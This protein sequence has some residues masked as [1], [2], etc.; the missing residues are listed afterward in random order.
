[1]Y[2]AIHLWGLTP[3]LRE[4]ISSIYRDKG[5]EPGDFAAPDLAK[6]A[7]YWVDRPLTK[8]D[9]PLREQIKES[10][11]VIL[12]SSEEEDIYPFFDLYFSGIGLTEEEFLR[13]F[14]ARIEYEGELQ[15]N[16]RS[17]GHKHGIPRD[18]EIL[19][20]C[21][22]VA[23]PFWVPDL[24]NKTGQDPEVIAFLKAHEEVGEELKAIEAYLKERI[25]LAKNAGQRSLNIDLACTGGQHRSV[26]FAENLYATF[27]EKY[28]CRLF[29][30]DLKHAKEKP[31]A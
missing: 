20:D 15:L 22:A 6:K 10:G 3:T 17:F 1:M 13:E 29:H 9:L 18:A 16:F 4:R 8:A 26:Y 19:F 27:N 7:F 11:G 24:R 31:H 5:F 12:H 30:R 14:R 28:D 23:N 25:A 2:H 21:R